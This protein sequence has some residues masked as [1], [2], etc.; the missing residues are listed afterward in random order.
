MSPHVAHLFRPQIQPLTPWFA[1]SSSLVGQFNPASIRT[2]F[3]LVYCSVILA[4]FGQGAKL[5]KH[6]AD[7]LPS[8]FYLTIPGGVGGGM[9]WIMFV[10]AILACLS[11]CPLRLLCPGPSKPRV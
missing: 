9:Y 1:T 2:G 10:F 7:V 8:L 3:G 4:Y 6:G 11:K 5:I